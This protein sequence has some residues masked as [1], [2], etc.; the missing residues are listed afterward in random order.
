MTVK[1]MGTSTEATR[2]SVPLTNT[3]KVFSALVQ[4]SREAETMRPPHDGSRPPRPIGVRTM[5]INIC[6]RDGG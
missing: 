1:G 2:S 3:E 5:R 6:T 4:P